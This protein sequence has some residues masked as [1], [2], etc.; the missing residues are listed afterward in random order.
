MYCNNNHLKLID[1]KLYSLFYQ[2]F[3]ENARLILCA[4][5]SLLSDFSEIDD[6][7]SAFEYE[8]SFLKS[9][10]KEGF[11]LCYD[12]DAIF[13]CEYSPMMSNILKND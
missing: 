6:A 11:S 7:K 9:S 5:Y 10:L 1:M 2:I 3:D 4:Y 8:F 12:L 13:C